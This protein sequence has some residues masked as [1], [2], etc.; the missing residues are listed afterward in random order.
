MHSETW[1]NSLTSTQIDKPEFEGFG[2]IP[3]LSRDCVITEKIDGTNAQILITDYGDLFVGSR[4]KWIT[5]SD[6]NFGF[7]RWA[8]EN[9]EEIMKLGPGR[10]FGEWWGKGIQRQYGLNEKRFS[11]F[12]TSVWGDDSVRP[13]CCHV[14][15]VI[16]SCEFST[17]VVSK[18]ID[19]LKTEGSFASPGYY[20]P[21]GII[22]YHVAL[23]GYFKKTIEG[24]ESP[25]GSYAN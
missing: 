4:K 22:V 1:R 16:F 10:H 9:R 7:A 13:S 20:S 24:D 6:D 5:P 14:V 21:E 19:R 17:E 8:E 3:R 15:P 2:K 12:N 11:L 25:K 23:N 18:A